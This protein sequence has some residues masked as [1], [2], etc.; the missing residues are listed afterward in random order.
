MREWKTIK[1]FEGYYDLRSDGLLYCHPRKRTKGGYTYGNNVSGYLMK[2][3]S[4]GKLKLS[5][6]LHRLVY[7]T[8]V[9]PIPEGYDV[10]HINHVKIDNRVENLCL[11]E[12]KKHRKAHT[13]ESVIVKSKPVAQY[14]KNGE[15]V[16]NYPSGAEAERQ[17]G[18]CNSHIL[19]CCNG[20]RKSAGGYLW[21]FI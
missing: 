21:M 4:K 19:E 8:F 18:I 2:T 5:I 3:L 1:D 20:K 7:E 17:T 11:V 12:S 10:H 13:E 14:T 9:G 16:S 6:S 15:F